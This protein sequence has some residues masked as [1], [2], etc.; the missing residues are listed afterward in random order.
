MGR[1]VDRV[2]LGDDTLFWESGDGEEFGQVLFADIGLVRLLN[3]PAVEVMR[4]SGPPSIVLQVPDAGELFAQLRTVLVRLSSRQVFAVEPAVVNNYM[5][6]AGVSYVEDDPLKR[7]ADFQKGVPGRG[8][9]P[10]ESVWNPRKTSQPIGVSATVGGENAPAV[11]ALAARM[12]STPQVHALFGQVRIEGTD[13]YDYPCS[14]DLRCPAKTFHHPDCLKWAASVQQSNAAWRNNRP[15]D[16]PH[17]E[18][19]ANDY[20]QV[21]E[22]FVPCS[23]NDDCVAA[24]HYSTCPNRPWR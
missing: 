10:K 14:H 2:V 18:A 11:A 1:L 16:V 3:P 20:G 13:T 15:A 6:A 17:D 23:S 8:D 12:A 4:S 7:W 22:A 9:V 5:S 21:D 19:V 24:S